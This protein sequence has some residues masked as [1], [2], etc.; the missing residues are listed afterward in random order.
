MRILLDTN[1]I[2][3]RELN[4]DVNQNI[5]NLYYWLDKLHHDKIIHPKTVVEL[6]GYYDKSEVKVLETKLNAY[7]NLRSEKSPN[8]DFNDTLS[9]HGYKTVKGDDIDNKMLFE[10]FLGRVDALISED[11]RMLNKATVLGI[12]EKVYTIGEFITKC[13]EENPSFINYSELKV[14]KMPMGELNIEDDF[15]KSLLKSYPDFRNWFHKKCDEDIYASFDKEQIQGF[16]YLK[17]EN[18]DEDYSNFDKPMEPMKRMKIGTFKVNSTGFRLGER[19]L[20]IAFDNAKVFN[21]NQ[22]YVTMF[23]NSETESLYSFL[24]KWGFFEYCNNI[25]TGEVILI[26]KLI[27]DKDLSPVGNFPLYDETAKKFFLPIEPGYHRS[28]FSDSIIRN[29]KNY[30]VKD[31]M[32]SRY[33]I[34][35]AYISWAYTVNRAKKGD[36]VLIYRKGDKYP[37]RYTSTVTSIAIISNV[38]SNFR[39][40]EHFLNTCE[41]RSVFPEDDLIKFW[42]D[43]SQKLSVIKLLYLK[44]LSRNVIL[45]E[46]IEEGMFNYDEGPR[47]FHRLSEEDFAKILELSNTEF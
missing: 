5:M 33:A 20:K 32:A 37:K 11:K 6:S 30:K 9:R 39:S 24:M 16:L 44:P 29:E 17:F 7:N 3:Y 19:F 45:N 41:N 21:V 12:D 42:N 28:L 2:L 47:P 36:I 8:K 34:K 38:I 25:D 23:L 26:K 15:F 4:K 18:E 43:N 27:F 14:I 40:L 22:I 1:I 46:L 35:K 31:Q 10:V 13:T